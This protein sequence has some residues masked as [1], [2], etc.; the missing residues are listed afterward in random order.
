MKKVS[1]LLLAC[2]MATSVFVASC[3]KDDDNNNTSTPTPTTP[4]L[5]DRV[6]GTTM[7][8]DPNNPGTMIEKGRLTLR[9]VVDSSILVIAADA[10]LAPYFPVLF[11]ELGN[12]N[13]SGLVAL[14]ENFTDFMCVATGSKNASYGYTGKNMKDAHDPA[15]NNRMGMKA[16]KADFDKFVGDIG[17][18]LAKNGVTAQNNKQLV[19]D[20]VALLYTTEADIVQR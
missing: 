4:S 7:V 10:Q 8:N 1:Y 14:S 2:L 12:N 17:I 9:A 16:N 19:D 5:Y 13:T 18:G 3:S 20:L 15:K 6:G 11:A